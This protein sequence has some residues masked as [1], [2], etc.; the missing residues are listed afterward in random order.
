[1]TSRKNDHFQTPSPP[2]SHSVTKTTAPL[3]NDVTDGITPPSTV[4]HNFMI[5]D[6]D[7]FSSF[8]GWPSHILQL[9]SFS[10]Y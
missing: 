3:K 5:L 8:K 6:Q 7:P 1:M 2:V 4:T 10:L 9:Q